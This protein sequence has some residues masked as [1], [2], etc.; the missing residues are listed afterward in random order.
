M[1][2]HPTPAADLAERL[3]AAQVAFHV[4]RWTGVDQSATVAA[5]AERLLD[6]AGARPVEE[7]VAADLVAG[8][9]VRSLGTVPASGAVGGI[10]ELVVDVVSAGPDEPFALGEAVARE[11]VEGLVDELLAL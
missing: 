2:A 10:L 6:A 5:V 8:I 1:S 11:H 9:V 4:E 3:L 7:L